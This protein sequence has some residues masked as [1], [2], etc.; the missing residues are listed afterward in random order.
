MTWQLLAA[1]MLA[2]PVQASPYAALTNPPDPVAQRDELIA[3][4]DE[5]CL[6][7]F[8]DDDAT[9]RAAARRGGTPLSTEQVRHML[10]D[11]PGIGW[12]LQGRTGRLYVA[13]EQAPPY[14]SCSLRTMTVNGFAD[15]APYQALAARYERGRL[16][17]PIPRMERDMGE[18]HAVG[19]G[20]AFADPHGNSEM[21][22]VAITRASEEHR[23]QGDTAVEMRF[24]HQ[25]YTAPVTHGS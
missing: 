13:L 1:A 9:A 18:L 24:E 6:R 8:P 12:V 10:H 23:A 14:H 16:F 19:F 17:Q 4:Y 15:L 21:L 25:F 3:L 22:L 5:I 11:D 7:A 2:G 20:E